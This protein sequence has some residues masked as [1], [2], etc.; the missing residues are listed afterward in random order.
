MSDVP[1]IEW[2]RMMFAEFDKDGSGS[3]SVKECKKM[4]RKLKVSDAEVESLVSKHDSSGDGEL[5]Y[6]EFVAFLMDQQTNDLQD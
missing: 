6:D 2:V 4:L 5:Q 3:I 1:R